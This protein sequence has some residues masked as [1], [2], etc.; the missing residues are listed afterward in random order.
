MCIIH[1]KEVKY[2]NTHYPI[3][4]NFY[5]EIKYCTNLKLLRHITRFIKLLR[6]R[7]IPV[8]SLYI[9]GMKTIFC[10]NII[11]RIYINCGVVLYN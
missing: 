1:N 11:D 7:I 9:S 3:T 4:V 5:V 6:K 8:L 2:T 10:D